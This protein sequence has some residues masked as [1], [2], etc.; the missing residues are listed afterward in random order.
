MPEY[1]SQSDGAVVPPMTT[2]FSRALN[3][4]IDHPTNTERLNEGQT[5]L[6]MLR[7]LQTLEASNA[8]KTTT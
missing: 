6:A 4:G 3:S 2:M 8:G 7:F 1:S 5:T